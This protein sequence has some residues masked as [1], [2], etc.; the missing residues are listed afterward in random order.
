MKILDYIIIVVFLLFGLAQYNDADFYLWGPVY[1][2]ISIIGM[3]KLTGRSYRFIAWF[4]LAIIAIWAI[5]YFPKMMEWVKQGMPNIAGS[6]KAETPYIEF[7]R[8]F[9]GL[10]LC[11]LACIY[12]LFPLKSR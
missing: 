2:I 9:F 5:S 3:L 10:L 8:E 12:F 6:M 4:A 1:L 11:A 7:T